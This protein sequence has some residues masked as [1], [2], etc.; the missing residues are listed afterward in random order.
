MAGA[1]CRNLGS[2]QS[3]VEIPQSLERNRKCKAKSRSPKWYA[4]QPECRPAQGLSLPLPWLSGNNLAECLPCRRV[5]IRNH[6]RLRRRRGRSSGLPRW[7]A[8]SNRSTSSDRYECACSKRIFPSNK[9]DVLLY[10]RLVALLAHVDR[11]RGAFP[12][13][14]CK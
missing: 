3:R 14:S 2:A 10:Y 6:R 7:L 8:E 9:A 12:V 5:A 1:K 11:S 4:L 13:A